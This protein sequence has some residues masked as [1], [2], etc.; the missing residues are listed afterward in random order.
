MAKRMVG[1][2]S[3]LSINSISVLS[4][5]S[6]ERAATNPTKDPRRTAMAT[7]TIPTSR[8]DRDP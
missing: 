8:A 1:K 5:N 4:V 3:R 6:P 7:A 2:D